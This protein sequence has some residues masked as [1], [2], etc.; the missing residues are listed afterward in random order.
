MGRWS[1]TR[2]MRQESIRDRVKE[3]IRERVNDGNVSGDGNVEKV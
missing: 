2:R 1:E 3:S